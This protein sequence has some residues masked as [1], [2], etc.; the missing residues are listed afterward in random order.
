MSL[1]HR[2]ILVVLG[3]LG[4]ASLIGGLRSLPRSSPIMGKTR[5]RLANR[6]ATGAF[7]QKSG[8]RKQVL[9]KNQASISLPRPGTK[10]RPN[11]APRYTVRDLGT[12]G[13]E[14]SSAVDIN[15]IGQVVGTSVNR[16][17]GERAFLW[18]QGMM[19]ELPTLAGLTTH[20]YALNNREQVVGE[21]LDAGGHYHAVL[22]AGRILR[23]LGVVDGE[24]S[25]ATA[26]ND[27]G[28]VVGYTMSGG[29]RTKALLWVKGTVRDLGT[30]G[31]EDSASAGGINKSGQVVGSAATGGYGSHVFLWSDEV[32]RNLGTTWWT[33]D[34]QNLRLFDP[35][36][37]GAW[38]SDI[39]DRGQVV[40]GSGVSAHG[41]SQDQAFLW[42]EGVMLG[43]GTLSDRGPSWYG[44]VNSNASAINYAGLVVGSS[45]TSE[46]RSHAF[47]FSTR[48]DML[49]L[50]SRIDP[51]LHWE[52]ESA[53]AIND[54]GQI[55]GTGRLTGRQRAYLLTPTPILSS[56]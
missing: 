1:A 50:N 17:G 51:N 2:S 35:P 7:H 40:G 55:V 26:I 53:N 39:N 48:F 25:A 44:L 47:I 36:Y 13:G 49:D 31:G 34:L 5:G 19:R 8:P 20:A 22:W 29:I 54:A 21:S 32:M 42:S 15:D 23:D 3:V 9:P 10:P 38:A 6:P 4:A 41:D 56:S 30:L 24:H 45:T 28:Q 12:L 43:L 27:T 14:W 46:G 16:L 52:L 18:G 37:S 33:K 11:L